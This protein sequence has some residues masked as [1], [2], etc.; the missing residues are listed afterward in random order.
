MFPYT[1][2]KDP[3]LEIGANKCE[4]AMS[5][6]MMSNSGNHMQQTKFIKPY[7]MGSKRATQEARK[8]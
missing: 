7:H 2:P 4:V 8:M 1:T 6:K 5:Q 3:Y